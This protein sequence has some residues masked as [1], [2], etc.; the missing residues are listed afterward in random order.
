MFGG[1]LVFEEVV[2]F[3]RGGSWWIE[4]ETMRATLTS[5][6]LWKPSCYFIIFFIFEN[7][8]M[9]LNIEQ[10]DSSNRRDMVDLGKGSK[11]MVESSNKS[12]GVYVD[13]D[14]YLTT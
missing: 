3:L 10:M 11:S 8:E 4:Q 9:I 7:K 12:L 5:S 14:I 6:H 1:L 13:K 2:D